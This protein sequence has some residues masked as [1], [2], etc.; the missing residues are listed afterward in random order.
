MKF[1]YSDD[2]K[3]YH[4]LNYHLRRTF[5]G[6][7]VRIPLDG[8]FTCPNIDGKC[9]VGGCIYC[10]DRG[11]GDFTQSPLLSIE[12]QYFAMRER[13]AKKWD[14]AR[15][16]PYLQA[17]TNTYAPMEKLRELYEKCLVLP[18]VC[19]FAVA[20]RADCI[21]EEI[22]DYFYDISKRTYLTVELGLQTVHDSTARLINRGHTFEDFLK[23]YG[24]L[25]ERGINICVHLINGLPHENK[26]M[27][28]ESIRQVARLAPHSV[29]LHLLYILSYTP[30]AKMLETGE[31]SALSREQ[32]VDI[33][34]SQLELLPAE[35]VVGR[36]TGD[37][38]A[39]FLT[40]PMWSLKKFC[41]LNEI[42]KEFVRRDTY[43]GIYADK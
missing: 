35:I 16:I 20:T 24:L 40:A 10:S 21:T 14:S 36:L 1:P 6:K 27:M 8:G 29:K 19:G 13:M 37:A 23:G 30:I 39:E 26:D 31:L 43:Q 38:P 34:V 32:Y 2:N 33:T 22:A 3:R 9:G 5:G 15:F 7:T 18:D 42:D 12:E 17:H 11:S 41:V 28:L 25:K 4:T